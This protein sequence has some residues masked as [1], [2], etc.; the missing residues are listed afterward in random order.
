M[1]KNTTISRVE[2]VDFVDRKAL[3]QVLFWLGAA[4]ADRHLGARAGY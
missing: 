2:L 1:K 3:L 4:L